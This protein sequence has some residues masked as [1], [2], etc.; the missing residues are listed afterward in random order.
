MHTAVLA[1]LVVVDVLVVV[2]TTRH[3]L[4]DN[5]V[6][7]LLAYSRGDVSVAPGQALASLWSTH[8]VDLLLLWHAWMLRSMT[9]WVSGQAGSSLPLKTLHGAAVSL[10]DRGVQSP[11]DAEYAQRLACC[12]DAHS[13]GV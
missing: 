2:T 5:A 1:V 13:F 10:A 8:G 3:T 4:S 6:P 9:Q 7:F 12:S 11:M